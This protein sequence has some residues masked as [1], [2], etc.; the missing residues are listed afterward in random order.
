[1]SCVWIISR[2]QNK[3]QQCG[4]SCDEDEKYCSSHQ[5]CKGTSQTELVLASED[6]ATDSVFEDGYCY[7]CYF[8]RHIKSNVCSKCRK[9][10]VYY[11]N[12]CEYCH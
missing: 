7:Q 11:G 9:R 1:M 4:N 5:K 12:R 3:G 6:T 8:F 10:P 2:G